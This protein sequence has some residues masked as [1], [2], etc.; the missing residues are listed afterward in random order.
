VTVDESTKP[1]TL[2]VRFEPSAATVTQIGQV[3]KKA[4]ESDPNNTAP[5][6]LKYASIVS[7]K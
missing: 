1:V 2:R 3:V 5:V 6:E 7:N 4:L